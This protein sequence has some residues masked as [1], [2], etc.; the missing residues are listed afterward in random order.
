MSNAPITRQ[1]LLAA[2]HQSSEW[3]VIVIG[4]GA[5]GLGT[6]LEAVT[7]GYKTLLL[8]Q[9]DF[10]KGTSSRSTKL[11]HGG[12]RYLA[13][14]NLK[15]VRSALRERGRL[16]RNAPHLVKDLT[17]LVPAY[18]WWSKFYYGAGLKLYDYLAG[19]LNLGASRFLSR[20][21]AIERMPTLKTEGLTGGILYH[22]GQFDDAR[23]AI[24][25]LSTF[26]EQGGTAL[27]YC[28]VKGLIKENNKIFGVNAV[29]RETEESF[30]LRAK[31]VVNATGVFV[32]TIRRMDNPDQ[33]NLLSPS[34]GIHLVV[35]RQFQPGE[36]AMMIPKTEDGRVL[37]A[38]PW[39]NKIVLGTTDTPVE[40]VAIEPRALEIE[41]D[42][43]LRTAAQYLQNPP[44]RK[45]VLSVFVGQRPLVKSQKS[46][47][48]GS[49]ATLSREHVIQVAESGLITV[50]G[51]KWTTYREMGEEV[52][53]KAIAVAHLP[54]SKSV[55]A[56]LKLHGWTEKAEADPLRLYG[57]DAE[58]VQC[59][60]GADQ[61]L[62]TMLPYTEAEVRW[63]ARYEL[64]RTVEDVL[65]RRTRSLFL[66]AQA[67]LDCAVRVAQILAEE[68][69]RDETWQQRQ[70]EE[71]GAIAKGYLLQ[72]EPEASSFT[73][74]MQPQS[75]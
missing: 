49:T 22:D 66:D 53:E 41:I 29:D 61:L 12:V 46:D 70:V 26:L 35:D 20:N 15:L 47:G 59:L 71:Y 72:E 2:V 58:Q 54:S 60:P 65:A 36:S 64:A 50:M 21:E 3:D 14:G 8:E 6:A 51:G 55:T 39:H 57:S 43:I 27:N 45:D 9:Y 75:V 62:H 17:F 18:A 10:A 23:L 30:E 52:V 42:F 67:S 13:Q 74:E 37:F 73:P 68:L 5:T 48:V 16:R 63:G 28:T 32:D 11:V 31:V 40:N 33:L 44:T 24:T 34:Q 56:D 4:G 19:R 38:L 1:N 69:G 25:L 7:R